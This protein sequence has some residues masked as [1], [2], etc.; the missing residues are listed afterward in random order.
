VLPSRLILFNLT[1]SLVPKIGILNVTWR[2]SE[3]LVCLGEVIKGN[4]SR[5]HRKEI[6]KEKQSNEKKTRK[7][8]KI[9]ERK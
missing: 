9:E 6:E 3:M 8:Q 4:T 2:S 1:F 5:D 7:H